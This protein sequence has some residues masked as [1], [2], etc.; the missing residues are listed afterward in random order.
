MEVQLLHSHCG[1][2]FDG[3]LEIIGGVEPGRS[4]R[5]QTGGSHGLAT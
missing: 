3:Y 1:Y 2:G 4:G 5:K